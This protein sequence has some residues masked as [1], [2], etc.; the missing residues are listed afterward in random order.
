LS[1]HIQS[2]AGTKEKGKENKQNERKMKKWRRKQKKK[3]I[4][5]RMQT[6]NTNALPLMVQCKDV[7]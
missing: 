3:E 1:Y 7:G 4:K 5:K 2:Q 6:S